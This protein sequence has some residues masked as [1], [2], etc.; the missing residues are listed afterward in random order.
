MKKQYGLL[1]VMGLLFWLLPFL[2]GAENIVTTDFEIHIGSGETI[3]PDYPDFSSQIGEGLNREDF[4]ITYSMEGNA[5]SFDEEGR[6]TAHCEASGNGYMLFSVLYTPRKAGIGEKTVFQGKLWVHEPLTEM[7]VEND[8]N[9]ISLEVDVPIWVTVK[10]SPYA[11]QSLTAESGDPDVVEAEVMHIGAWDWMLSLNPK[12][13]GSTQVTVTAYNGLVLEIPVTVDYAPTKVEFGA[14]KYTGYVG[15]VIDLELD[16][17]GATTLLR[18][19]FVTGNGKEYNARDFLPGWNRQ[20]WHLFHALAS[21]KYTVT[22]ETYN[23]HTGSTQVEVFDRMNCAEIKAEKSVFNAGE[24]VQV[25][26]LAADG[27]LLHLPMKITEG[28]DRVALTEEKPYKLVGKAAGKVRLEVENADGSVITKELEVAEQPDKAWFA[29]EEIEMEIGESRTLEV[30]F[31]RGRTDYLYEVKYDDTE[32]AYGLNCIRLEGDL[33]VAQAPGCA[34]ITL[35]SSAL[36]NGTC[37]VTV[38]EGD[39]AVYI[40]LP[41]GPL[42]LER[43]CRLKVLDQAGKEYPAVFGSD[44]FVTLSL[45]EDGTATGKLPGTASIWAVL[46]DGRKLQCDLQVASIPLWIK[47]DDISCY[48]EDG[49]QT[50]HPIESDLGSGCPR[51]NEVDVEV[52]DETIVEYREEKLIPKKAGK[53]HVTLTAKYG[54]AQC[55][56]VVEVLSKEELRVQSTEIE[57]PS[58]YG[59]QLPQVTDIQGNVIPVQWEIV[60]Q[61]PGPGN[62]EETGFELDGD[63]LRCL[64]PSAVCEVT[65]T[66]DFGGRVQVNAKGYRLA[67]EIQFQKEEYVVSKGNQIYVRVDAVQNEEGFGACKTGPLLWIVEDDEIAALENSQGMDETGNLQ[68]IKGLNHGQ[69]T[70]Y[71]IGINGMVAECTV[72]V[73]R[74]KVSAGDVN[75]DNEVNAADADLLVKYLAEQDVQV[76]FDGAE[77]T[78]DESIDTRDALNLL[79]YVNGWHNP[80]Y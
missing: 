58:G 78:G 54:D 20:E 11:H 14:E 7:K 27:T 57:V 3:L 1:L 21:G 77:V 42:G 22:L 10:T 56:F 2:A 23:N 55:V 44:D 41:D 31:D 40:A 48:L 64:W 52:A 75:A 47:R 76:Y 12:K 46:E 62:P 4:Y 18:Y 29:Q 67:D 8:W 16:L 13:C 28:S 80:L 63:V 15:D 43:T 68:Q 60:Y 59:L 65:G 25:E 53:T 5:V 6:C 45:E 66:A 34:E 39:K 38:K 32:P 50:L 73:D 61:V 69:T 17:G 74:S 72:T 70:V 79:R 24:A 9:R 51:V 71:A 19:M 36:E 30:L 35:L 26:L 37:K 49:A 33:V